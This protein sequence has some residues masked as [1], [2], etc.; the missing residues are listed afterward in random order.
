MEEDQ[1]T[2]TEGE[3]ESPGPFYCH[4]K[5]TIGSLDRSRK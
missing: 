4:G 5:T 1:G 3:W 2:G